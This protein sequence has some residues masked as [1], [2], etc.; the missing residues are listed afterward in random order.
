MIS[1]PHFQRDFQLEKQEVYDSQ[2]SSPI[3]KSNLGTKRLE[4]LLKSNS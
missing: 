2:K 3:Q 1:Q 4:A